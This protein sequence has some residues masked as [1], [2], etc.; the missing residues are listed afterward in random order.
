MRKIILTL[1]VTAFVLSTNAQINTPAPSPF[2]SITQVVGL[3]EVT[4]E[5]SR[6]GMKGRTIFGDLVPYGQIWR[7]G[8]NARTKITFSSDVKIG[9]NNLKKGTYAIFTKPNAK[10]WDVYFYTE[11]KGNG[12]PKELDETKIAAS[13]T[14]DVQKMPIKI[15]TFTITFDEVTKNSADIGFL[16]EDV[17]LPVKIETPTDKLVTSSINKV[18]SGPSANDL[19]GAA[20]YYYGV[21]KD[22]KLAQ[23]W[24]DKAVEMTKDKPR[25]WYLRQQALIHAKNGDKKGAIKAAK[26]SLMLAE[27]NGNKGYINMNKASLKEWG[28]M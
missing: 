2:Q 12:A 28:A 3:T 23:S 25:F 22:M 16:W 6:P 19:Y 27:K 15:E 7:T 1:F 9:N 8:A 11:H 18:M 24:I 14:V 26:E 10:S 5:F 20:S 17:Y 4:I 21:E 13:L